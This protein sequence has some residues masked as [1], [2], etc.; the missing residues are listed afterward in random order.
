M[1]AAALQWAARLQGTPAAY[2]ALSAYD[3]QGEGEIDLKD[4][5]VVRVIEKFDEHGDPDWWRV[6]R[7]DS[8]NGI[9]PSTYLENVPPSA[10]AAY[11]QARMRT[12]KSDSFDEME[13]KRASVDGGDRKSSGGMTTNLPVP[14]LTRSASTSSNADDYEG[15]DGEQLTTLD[16][17]VFGSAD[18]IS[19]TLSNPRKT[20]TINKIVT[21]VVTTQ[22]NLRNFTNK[23]F[24]IRRKYED[25][26]WLHDYLEGDCPDTIV[27]PLPV[28]AGKMSKL[29]GGIDEHWIFKRTSAAQAFITRLGNHRKFREH[30]M[31]RLLLEGTPAEL[32]RAKKQKMAQ[33]ESFK[34]P[35]ESKKPDRDEKLVR[36]EK[37]YE[38]LL[39]QVK[40]LKA[41]AENHIKNHKDA[42]NSSSHY[43][44]TWQGLADNEPN[45]TYL[46]RTM[47]V[48][49]YE[50]KALESNNAQQNVELEKKYRQDLKNVISYVK[51][52]LAYIQRVYDLEDTVAYWTLQNQTK[53]E[54]L[55]HKEATLNVIASSSLP[56]Q[57]KTVELQ[58]GADAVIAAQ[59]AAKMEKKE[60]K[61]YK[62]KQQ[63]QKDLS[64]R[65]NELE[66]KVQMTAE[67]AEE[68][69]RRLEG[70][71][72]V[73]WE[74][75]AA[76]DLQKEVELQTL[77]RM[78]IQAKIATFQEAVQKFTTLDAEIVK[79]IDPSVRAIKF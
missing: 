42:G 6:E 52:A 79:P 4:G 57:P 64:K 26:V 22:T 2:Y 27:P 62:K 60:M 51:E 59:A 55:S 73:M 28:A 71:R 69:K 23:G 10:D 15:G 70:T 66:K 25:F 61:E 63:E 53:R 9:V 8:V 58:P 19:I 45:D 48:L 38:G 36:A 34:H 12:L 41:K 65:I 30:P 29:A 67:N 14:D 18:F 75:L 35:S 11:Y 20:G 31:F 47:G 40:E 74:E 49:A 76:F 54:S 50:M 7:S 17:R 16:P 13:P 78:W 39:K 44:N 24:S 46:R 43:H 68:A 72:A 77:H 37:Y 5:E 56:P 1:S 33:K 32:K 3:G 21:W